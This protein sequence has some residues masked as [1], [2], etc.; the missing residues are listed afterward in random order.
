MRVLSASLSAWAFAFCARA[1]RLAFLRAYYPPRFLRVCY[2]PRAWVLSAPHDDLHVLSAVH[3]CAIR[4]AF[5]ACAILQQRHNIACAILQQQHNIQAHVR[6]RERRTLL[7]SQAHGRA[8]R[9]RRR[10][11]QTTTAQSSLSATLTMTTSTLMEYFIMDTNPSTAFLPGGPIGTKLLPGRPY[12]GY[13]GW[14][15]SERPGQT[16]GTHRSAPGRTRRGAN[17]RTRQRDGTSRRLLGSR[18]VSSIADADRCHR[19]RLLGG[20]ISNHFIQTFVDYLRSQH[21]DKNEKVRA[22]MSC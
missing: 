7:S 5:C 2:P 18:R 6:H 19:P 22:G 3:A 14:D 20:I 21:N 1:I 8:R 4:L 15:F 17:G 12:D 13:A 16:D 10:I 11:N 9:N